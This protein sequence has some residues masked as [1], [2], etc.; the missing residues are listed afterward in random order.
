MHADEKRSFPPF[1]L[2]IVLLDAVV[3]LA[4]CGCGWSVGWDTMPLYGRGLRYAGIALLAFGAL[5]LLGNAG[6]V[7]DSHPS[8]P[9]RPS[10]R[11]FT[12]RV[13][14]IYVTFSPTLVLLPF[15]VLLAQRS[16]ASACL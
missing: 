4:I 14:A 2:K 5:T 7:T 15:S 16:A 3:A 12:S 8:T 1:L 9:K 6:A 11:T 13:G 10:K